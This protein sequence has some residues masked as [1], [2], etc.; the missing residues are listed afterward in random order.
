[1]SV[2][3]IKESE[4]RNCAG[5]TL[6]SRDSIKK[7]SLSGSSV[8]LSTSSGSEIFLDCDDVLFN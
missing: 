2:F 5:S 6:S 7:V 4:L 8:I 1:M 3:R